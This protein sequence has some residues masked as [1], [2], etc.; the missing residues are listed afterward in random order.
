M[1]TVR[2][3]PGGKEDVVRRRNMRDLGF[4]TSNLLNCRVPGGITCDANNPAFPDDAQG[5]EAHERKIGWTADRVRLL[6]GVIESAKAGGQNVPESL[7]VVL[8]RRPGAK[9]LEQIDALLPWAPSLE[10]IRWRYAEQPTPGPTRK[11][12]GRRATGQARGGRIVHVATRRRP[13][14]TRTIGRP[15][16]R[17]QRVPANGSTSDQWCRRRAL[18]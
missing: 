2:R 7:K 6:H 5:R 11:E 4:A 3:P 13:L 18:G 12:F 16:R 14:R 9:T 1:G 8:A 10:E 17:P 15:G